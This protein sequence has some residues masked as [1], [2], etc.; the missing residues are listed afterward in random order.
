MADAP[1]VRAEP[2]SASAFAE[3][4]DVLAPP[5][6]L[7]RTYFDDGLTN[8][9]PNAPA[10]L[11]VARIAATPSL[12]ITAIEMER[13]EFSS[14]SFIPIDVSRYVIVVAPHRADGKPDASNARAFIVPGSVGITYGVNVWHHP[15][16]VLDRPA[17]FAI[18]MWRDGSVGDEEFVKLEHPFRIELPDAA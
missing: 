2:I 15:I 11:S 14:Q 10:S 4:G 9:R 1:T 12:P 6:E 13:H 16:T 7:G 5:A 18:Q 17:T 3:F 8:A